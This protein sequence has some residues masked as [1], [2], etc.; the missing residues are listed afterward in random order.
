M[1]TS[2]HHL[3]SSS[4]PAEEDNLKPFMAW[5]GGYLRLRIATKRENGRWFALVE[6]FDIT[7][8]GDTENEAV[9]QMFDLLG[10]YLWAHFAD[11]NT[12]A[13]AKRPI[14][15]SLKLRIR[16][17]NRIDK[18]RRRAGGENLYLVPPQALNACST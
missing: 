13:D 17:D 18:L 9:Q 5:L 8:M 1:A 7:G 16:L 2:Q 11:G 12:F 3:Q 6:E 15:L 14:P 4:A 10:A